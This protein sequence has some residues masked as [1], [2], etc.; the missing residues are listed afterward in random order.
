MT[1][2]VKDKEE[3]IAEG[4]VLDAPE[5]AA[6]EVASLDQQF[7]GGVNPDE[8]TITDIQASDMNIEADAEAIVPEIPEEVA[9]N[10]VEVVHEEASISPLHDAAEE[11]GGSTTGNVI[12]TKNLG[13]KD[14]EFNTPST[15]P[16]ERN[17][18]ITFPSA[19]KAVLELQ[20][21]LGGKKMYSGKVVGK[22]ARTVN[23]LRS[24]ILAGHTVKE[25]VSIIEE[26]GHIE[27]VATNSAPVTALPV[28]DTLPVKPETNFVPAQQK[29]AA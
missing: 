20:H 12:S 13:V 8:K 7:D 16:E 11:V 3:L 24:F 17:N 29:I 6:A 22:F 2:E 23:A 10:N 4:A 21:G 1:T 9:A 18:V 25:P 27:A 19:N 15:A 14:G 26:A 28:P 5:Q